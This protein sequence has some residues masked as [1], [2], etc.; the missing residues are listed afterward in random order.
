MNEYNERWT[1]EKFVEYRRLKRNGF[2][3][4]QLIEHFGDDIWYS[5]LYNKKSSVLGFLDYLNEIKIHPSITDYTFITVNSLFYPYKKDHYTIF[6]LKDIEYVVYFM[7]YLVDKKTPTYNIMFST[8]KQF[9]IYYK[10]LKKILSKNKGV[11]DEEREYLK[12]IFEKK[13]NYFDIFPIVKSISYIIF[14]LYNKDIFNNILFS[15]GQTDNTVKINL[16]RN[17]I[18]DSFENIEET[19]IVDSENNIYYLYIKY[20]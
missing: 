4:K 5:G 19:K 20:I 8:K 16:Y 10:K 14:D 12:S 13:T 18:K 17:I 9:E 6:K 1:R 2:N 7:Y 11:S 3:D 15:I